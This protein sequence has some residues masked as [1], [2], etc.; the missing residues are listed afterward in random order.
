MNKLKYLLL[1]ICFTTLFSCSKE[2]EDNRKTY[3]TIHKHGAGQI[4]Y[5]YDGNDQLIG[6]TYKKSDGAT[7]IHLTYRQ[8]NAAGM[9]ER[10]DYNF[11]ANPS[12]KPY[13]LVEYDANARPAKVTNY[14]TDGISG[15]YD[16]YNYTTGR[17]EYRTFNVSGAQ[18]Y[19]RI[20]SIDNAGNVTSMNSL[21][22]DN[23]STWRLVFTGYDNKKA[24]EHPYKYLSIA[25]N[26]TPN[27]FSVNNY[28]G[29]EAYNYAVLDARYSCTYTYN[30]NEYA[31]ERVTT[32]LLSNASFQEI[33]E[34]IKR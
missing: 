14:A 20:Y 9:P 6:E 8:F 16:T 28:T 4:E 33:Y 10:I 2:E 29:Y 11:P 1:S 19:L 21:N 30:Q 24:P 27:F 13:L 17:I 26:E 18:Q 25:L 23:V 22:A 5:T 31:T 12:H 34:F 32:D 15:P 3:L 7:D